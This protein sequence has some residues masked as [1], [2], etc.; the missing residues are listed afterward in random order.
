MAVSVI[1]STYNNAEALEKSLWGYRYQ[2]YQDFELLIA[3]DGSSSETSDV[4][5]AAEQRL[6]CRVT[7]VWHEDIGFRKSRVLNQAIQRAQYD[8]LLFTDGDCIPR[9][10]FVLAHKLNS[11]PNFFLAGGSHIDVPALIHGNLKEEDIATQRAFDSSWLA[12]QGM[13]VRKC[14]RRLTRN[15][16][17]A[18][19]LDLLTPRPGVFVGCNGSVWKQ[20]VVAVNGFDSTSTYGSDDKELGARLTNNGVKSR[21][22]KHSLICIHLSH[23]KSYPADQIRRNR[24]KL[25]RI[26]AQKITWIEDG[27]QQS[28]AA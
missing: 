6:P 8:Y 26:K 16:P 7:H 11:R 27:I 2:W 3:D 5:S 18:K 17:M 14:R 13:D 22:L 1:I 12:S 20:D 15:R 28:K 21:R 19:F 25:R 10:D 9:N 23:P 24:E 4:I